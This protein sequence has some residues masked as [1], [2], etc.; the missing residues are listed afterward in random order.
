MPSIEVRL[1]NQ[2]YHLSKPHCSDIIIPSETGVHLV[3]LSKTF[4]ILHTCSDDTR[5]RMVT[6][7]LLTTKEKPSLGFQK[8]SSE[9]L[10]LLIGLYLL[11]FLCVY[12]FSFDLLYHFNVILFFIYFNIFAGYVYIHFITFKIT[13]RTRCHENIVL[14]I[15]I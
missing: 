15:P 5:F 2:N 10:I 7:S 8:L 4:T 13:L 3:L 14:Y 12:L 11:V 6:A 1:L 9:L